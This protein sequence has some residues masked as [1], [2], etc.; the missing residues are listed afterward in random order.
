MQ[1]LGRR[2]NGRPKDWVVIFSLLDQFVFVTNPEYRQ[3]KYWTLSQIFN[4]NNN[5]N[6]LFIE[7]K[8]IK[9]LQLFSNVIEQQ[10]QQQ[11]QQH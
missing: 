3:Y 2:K 4:D 6:T 7:D 9:K 8:Q 10:Q 11:Q 5:N 1:W